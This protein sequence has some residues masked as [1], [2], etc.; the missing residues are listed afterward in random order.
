MASPMSPLVVSPS[1]QSPSATTTPRLS[2]APA[3]ASTAGFGSAMQPPSPR[4]C[5]QASAAPGCLSECNPAATPLKL[6]DRLAEAVDGCATSATS[7]VGRSSM[8]ATSTA[9]SKEQSPVKLM[10]AHGGTSCEDSAPPWLQRG[11]PVLANGGKLGSSC[12]VGFKVVTATR[13]SPLK[14]AVRQMLPQE[15]DC[16]DLCEV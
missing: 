6:E 3:A 15:I 10:G 16:D 7:L 5:E 1:A 2:S 4:R 8:Q 9:A 11:G 13:E 12:T 14:A